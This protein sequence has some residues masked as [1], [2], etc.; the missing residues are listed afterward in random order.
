MKRLL[1]FMVSTAARPRQP[2]LARGLVTATVWM[3]GAAF[4]EG[5]GLL[6]EIVTPTAMVVAAEAEEKETG[7][8]TGA[9][10]GTRKKIWK[11]ITWRCGGALFILT[12]ERWV[13]LACYAHK[14]PELHDSYMAVERE[15]WPKMVQRTP[16]GLHIPIF[17][18]RVGGPT[19]K[20]NFGDQ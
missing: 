16:H 19:A 3:M 4:L 13:R 20:A 14:L 15:L 6:V 10:L 9:R 2:S 11:L 8:V 12:C 17:I 1:P 7:A 5:W 18:Y